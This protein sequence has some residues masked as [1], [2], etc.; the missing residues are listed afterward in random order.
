MLDP[1][2]PGRNIEAVPLLM[3]YCQPHLERTGRKVTATHEVEGFGMCSDCFRGRP[4]RGEEEHGG[5][6]RVQ[7]P[8][9]FL[10]V[11]TG[12][13]LKIASGSR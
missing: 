1:F 10:R 9:G 8:S 13:P 4:I 7:I 12:R 3:T 6:A 11:R 2:L 5:F